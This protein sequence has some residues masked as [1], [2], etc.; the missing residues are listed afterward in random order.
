MM[1]T[2]LVG[3]MIVCLTGC[4]QLVGAIRQHIPMLHRVIG[5]VYL[6]ACTLAAVGGLTFIFHRGCVGGRP[7]DAG[8]GLYGTCVLYCAAHTLFCARSR[9]FSSHREWA[10]RLFALAIG[11]WLFR[12]ENGFLHL[13]MHDVGHTEEF[14]GWADYAMD[15]FFF[16]PNLIVVE[17]YLAHTKRNVLTVR[18][19]YSELGTQREALTQGDEEEARVSGSQWIPKSPMGKVGAIVF[20]YSTIIAVCVG[21]YSFVGVLEK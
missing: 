7:M 2:H 3:G 8:F 9:D 16:V 15:Y 21:T 14:R 12:L 18:G 11:S 17:L 4:V 13:F 19:Q 6:I 10:L 5:Y 20:L 1:G